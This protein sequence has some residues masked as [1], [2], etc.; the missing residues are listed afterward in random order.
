MLRLEVIHQLVLSHKTIHTLTTAVANRAI[1]VLGPS[2]VAFLVAFEVSRAAKAQGTADVR[3]VE[4]TIEAGGSATGDGQRSVASIVLCGRHG[5]R[6]EQA[7]MIGGSDAV[8]VI[9]F[10]GGSVCVVRVRRH[11][12]VRCKMVLEV[13]LHVSIEARFIVANKVA[14]VTQTDQSRIR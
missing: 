8:R 3:T 7:R 14:A 4:S 11:G 13:D 6:T 9:A 12:P 10:E 5:R 2:L 1:Q